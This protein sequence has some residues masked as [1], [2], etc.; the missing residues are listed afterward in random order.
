LKSQDPAVRSRAS[1]LLQTIEGN[2]LLQG[3][4]VRLDFKDATAAEVLESLKNQ[5]GIEL[6]LGRQN[7]N[8]VAPRITLRDPEPVPFWKAIDR[9]CEAAGLVCGDHFSALP[10]PPFGGPGLVFSYQPDRAKAPS[11]DHGAFRINVL[12]LFYH[13]EIS[14]IPGLQADNRMKATAL[15]VSPDG[16]LDGEVLKNP[17]AH[18]G[19]V[20]GDAQGARRQDQPEEPNNGLDRT[21]RFRVELQIVPDRRMQISFNGP[22]ELLEAVDELGNSLRPTSNSEANGYN[23]RRAMFQRFG[24]RSDGPTSVLLH[25]PQNPGKLIKKLRGTLNISIVARW[26]QPVVIPLTNAAGKL[27]ETDEMRVV[28]ESIETDATGKPSVIELMI[29]ELDTRAPEEQSIDYPP[30]SP[31]A[32]HQRLI[33]GGIGLHNPLSRIQVVDARGKDT[34]SQFSSSQQGTGP[35]TLRLTLSPGSG[36]SEKIGLWSIVR[37]TAKIPF[38][39]ENLPMP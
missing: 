12:M 5:T 27:L 19:P 4:K 10:A 17:H 36:G 26:P 31:F 29:D 9:F 3:A 22:P 7:P 15:R 25:R 34:F 1:A 23:P 16:K 38:E 30:G 2:L 18:Q 8:S 33:H 24:G 39:F 20:S 14:Y 35:V 13:N 28:V 21:V 6:E 32:K 37:T 11:Y